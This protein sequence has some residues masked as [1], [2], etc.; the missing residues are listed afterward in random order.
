MKK[1][2]INRFAALLCSTLLPLGANAAAITLQSNWAGPGGKTGLLTFTYDDSINDSDASTESGRYS[3]PFLSGTFLYNGTTTYT[4]DAT[5]PNSIHM[6]LAGYN[7]G[8]PKSTTFSFVVKNGSDVQNVVVINEGPW[9]PSDSLAWFATIKESECFLTS[10][11]FL[12]NNTTPGPY[13][14]TSVSNVPVPAGAWLFGS[15]LV[16]LGAARRRKAAH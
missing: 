6:R 4:L 5:E 7:P 16:A 2:T 8:S 15:A 1:S 13:V 9:P 12:F 11:T 3:K 10:E 14:F